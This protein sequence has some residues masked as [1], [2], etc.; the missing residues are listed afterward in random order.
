MPFAYTQPCH[1]AALAVLHGLE[2][3][4]AD[5]A[6][7]LE[8]GCASGGNII[9]LAARFPKARFLGIDL[10][11]RHVDDGRQ[12][13][14]ALK[15]TNIELRQGDIAQ[16]DLSGERFDYVICHGVFSWAP[17]AAQ[18]AIFRICRDTLAPNGLA[19]ISYNVLPGWRLRGIVRDI[20]LH[21]AGSGAPRERVA[22]ARRALAEIAD[23]AS[24][25]DAYGQML[26]SEAARCARMPSAYILGEFLA[27]ENAPCHFSDFAERAGRHGLSFLCEADL[28]ASIAGNAQATAANLLEDE[29][30]KDFVI[31]RTFRRSVLIRTDEAGKALFPPSADRLRSLNASSRLQPS[32][33]YDDCVKRAL[34]RLVD[35]YPAT[36]ALTDLADGAEAARICSALFSLLMQG[37]ATASTLPVK[38]GHA[39]AERPAVWP[40]ARIE[41]AARQPWLTSLT[42][43]AVPLRALPVELIGHLDGSKD[44]RTLATLAG[45]QNLQRGLERLAE[46]ALLEPE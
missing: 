3:P 32:A 31:G 29:Q 5:A 9:P 30:R 41:A 19:I 42:H 25:T 2:P 6:N 7:V 17:S 36:I 8:L 35:A 44:R 28:S 13:I 43:E 20:C 1:L 24:E 22:R 34:L 4:A 11:Q 39:D 12:R 38:V 21:H 23:A 33:A 18:A 27:A 37:Q 15:L 45:E 46:H 26:R 16:A 10:A 14:G 40:L